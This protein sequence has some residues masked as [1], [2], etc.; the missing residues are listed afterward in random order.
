MIL[1]LVRHGVT[2]WNL[3]HRYQGSSDIPLSPRGIEQ[4]ELLGESIAPLEVDRVVASPLTRAR[5]TAQIAYGKRSPEILDELQ[6][7]SFG[8]WEGMTE[9]EIAERYP[10]SFAAFNRY[11]DGFRFPEGDPIDTFIARMDRLIPMLTG[12]G[13]ESLLA[14]THSGVIRHLLCRLLGLPLPSWRRFRISP[15]SLVGLEIKGSYS[16]L[17]FISGA[18]GRFPFSQKRT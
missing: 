9:Q 10:D 6:E 3:A 7:F 13:D 14:F 5:Q 16:S 17:L 1:Y 18:G 2:E 4:A 11:E 8:A 15:A 12:A